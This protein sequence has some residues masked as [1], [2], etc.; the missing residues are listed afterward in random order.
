MGAKSQVIDIGLARTAK[1]KARKEAKKRAAK[2]AKA[3]AAK[4]AKAGAG[5]AGKKGKA[6]RSAKGGDAKAHPAGTGRFVTGNGS[7]STHTGPK[8]GGVHAHP[9]EELRHDL[10]LACVSRAID[11]REIA[12]QKQSRVFFQISGA[13]HEALLLAL[14]HELRPGYDW[15]FRS[16]EHTS[17]LQSRGHLV[18][19]LLLEKKKK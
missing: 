6:G 18:C 14:A 9:A 11:D 2:A 8:S 19:R 15:F 1:K 12:L 5:G 16:E 10:L 4:G 7:R 3:A 17:E 13:G